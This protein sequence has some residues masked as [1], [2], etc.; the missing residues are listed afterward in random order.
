[1]NTVHEL[2]EGIR[3]GDGRTLAR[4]LTMVENGDPRAAVLLHELYDPSATAL[5]LGV[6]GPPGAGKSSMV[7]RLIAYW[8]GKGKKVGVLAV[9]PSSP[10]SGGALLGD[11]IRMQ[12]H[13]TDAG[14]FIRSMGSRGHLGGLSGST[15]DS[16]ELMIAAGYDP[17]MVE[18]VGVGQAEVEVASLADLTIL[19]L[20][21]GAGDEVQTMK[22]GI[23]EV[24]DVIVLNK[25]DAGGMDRLQTA[26]ESSLELVPD[27]IGRP[28][29]VRFS[30]KTGQG[31]ELL[32]EKILEE[33]SSKTGDSRGA[34]KR[35]ML[36]LESV[37][38]EKGRKMAASKVE[39]MFGG[40]EK[41][42]DSVLRGETTP[43]GI[44]ELLD[45]SFG[46]E[47]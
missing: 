31:L 40:M 37:L 12:E 19:V 11:R 4:A 17:V 22:A 32:V 29:V 47:D 8:R 33:A 36:V 26:V 30:A 35:A 7:N 14:V 6:T 28:P 42:I 41:A 15:R 27:G 24:A 5:T 20:V 39:E 44:G 38:R 2:A 1:L 23:M 25:A 34:R 10:F 46:E 21:P 9:D 3:S 18:T 13:A 43:Y 45:K 16:L